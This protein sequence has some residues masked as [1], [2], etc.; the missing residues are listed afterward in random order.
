MIE[1]ELTHNLLHAGDI[2]M[3]ICNF[4]SF[5]TLISGV[6]QSQTWIFNVEQKGYTSPH[7]VYDKL[8]NRKQRNSCI[9]F[10]LQDTKLC[11]CSL[12]LIFLT[13]WFL[14]FPRAKQ[15][16]LKWYSEWYTSQQKPTKL[17][18]LSLQELKSFICYLLYHRWFYDLWS[19]TGILVW[20][21]GD[22]YTYHSYP[23]LFLFVDTYTCNKNMFK[24]L[25]RRKIWRYKRVNQKPH[26]K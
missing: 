9:F 7:R 12:Q 19:Q 1:N 22:S 2:K 15:E 10:Y 26:I 17:A 14:G 8:L 20:F 4:I 21:R 16:F 3:C 24:L 11:A 18:H 13:H 25:V 5:F 23:Q 6:S